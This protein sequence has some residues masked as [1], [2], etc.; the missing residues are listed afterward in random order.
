MWLS[1]ACVRQN[2][3]NF[4]TSHAFLPPAVTKLSMLEIVCFLPSLYI[5][6]TMQWRTDR[7]MTDFALWKILTGHISATG[8]PIH[9][10]LGL[11]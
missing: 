4:D 8:R 7:P 2:S 6:T 1:I 10:M 3:E 9:F 11:G 5:L